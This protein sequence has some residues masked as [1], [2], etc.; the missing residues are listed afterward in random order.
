MV[1]SFKNPFAA[2]IRR[3][4]KLELSI[5]ED[6]AP[7][8]DS[9]MPVLEEEGNKESKMEEVDR[10]DIDTQVGLGGKWEGK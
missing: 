1:K 7:S 4:L 2:R 3:T 5:D 8:E 10:E 6:E 9:D